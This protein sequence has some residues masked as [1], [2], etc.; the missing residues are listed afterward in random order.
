MGRPFT[1]RSVHFLILFSVDTRVCT[2]G[3]KK[4]FTGSGL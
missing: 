4:G 1:G 2:G 3:R